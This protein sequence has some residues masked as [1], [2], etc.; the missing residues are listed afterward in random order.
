MPDK[1]FEKLLRD[2]AN[3]TGGIPDFAKDIMEE[4][5]GIPRTLLD[6]VDKEAKKKEPE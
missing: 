2:F 5:G 4:K 1:D 3:Q 6:E